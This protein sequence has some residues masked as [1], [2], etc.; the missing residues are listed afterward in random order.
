MWECPYQENLAHSTFRRPTSKL[1]RIF[2][3][4]RYNFVLVYLILCSNGAYLL[5]GRKNQ[6]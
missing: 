3:D 4:T 5:R 6:G 2:E 1:F